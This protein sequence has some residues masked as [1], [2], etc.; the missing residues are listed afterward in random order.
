MIFDG[1]IKKGYKYMIKN[2]MGAVVAM[3]VAFGASTNITTTHAN[4]QHKTEKVIQV[5]GST[6]LSDHHDKVEFTKSNDM[7]KIITSYH[8]RKTD[9]IKKIIYIP[10]K[11]YSI[12]D[13]TGQKDVVSVQTRLASYSMKKQGFH[14]QASF[15]ESFKTT[16]KKI[17]LSK[18][19][20]CSS[21]FSNKKSIAGGDSALDSCLKSA[22]GISDTK[23]FRVK[24]TLEN[25]DNDSVNVSIY[26]LERSYDYQLWESDLSQDVPS[27][28]YLGSGTLTRPLG[29]VIMVTN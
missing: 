17:S 15:K 10:I 24:D 13:M 11:D 29:L 19:V 25:V 20:F 16:D 14:D 3:T 28:S 6:T 27:D 21:D 22:Y 1:I 7:K 5:S 9:N 8:L 18:K 4:L 12:N 26:V 23:D 2:I